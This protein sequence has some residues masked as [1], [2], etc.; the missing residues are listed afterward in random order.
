MTR[1]ALHLVVLLTALWLAAPALAQGD[2]AFQR[3]G[4]ALQGLEQEA[5]YLERDLLRL[6][7]RLRH[8]PAERLTVYLT[9]SPASPL[10]PADIRL[11]I[12][13]GPPL[14]LALDASRRRALAKGGAMR[15]HRTRLPAGTH[16]LRLVVEGT[17][18]GEAFS[19][20]RGQTFTTGRGPVNLRLHLDANDDGTPR[21][22]LE[23][24]P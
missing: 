21:L 9:M 23:S 14:A 10:Q 7:E 11:S 4:D 2:P 19:G 1:T 16:R 8:P 20:T 24:W 5:V 22:T 18:A 6:E 15:L 13:G 17:A 12:D 3:Q